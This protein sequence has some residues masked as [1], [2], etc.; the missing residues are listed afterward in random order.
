MTSIIILKLFLLVLKVFSTFL[1]FQFSA[2]SLVRGPSLPRS[3]GPHSQDYN[4]RV[5]E[6]AGGGFHNY[7]L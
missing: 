3:I 5:N 6:Q 4:A 1:N 7:H 2:A